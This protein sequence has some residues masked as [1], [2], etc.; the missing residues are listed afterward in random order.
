MS[1]A[2]AFAREGS[3]CARCFCG[4]ILFRLFRPYPLFCNGARGRWR[5]SPVMVRLAWG[6]VRI[7]EP[8][9]CEC[10]QALKLPSHFHSVILT[11]SQQQRC[12]VLRPLHP[13]RYCI[14]ILSNPH[15]SR[16]LIDQICMP[17]ALPFLH[18]LHCHPP[19]ISLQRASLAAH[20]SDTLIYL[21]ALR[22]S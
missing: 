22:L 8:D 20:A 1:S 17:L 18:Q 15:F 4:R 19:A 2:D 11:S 5:A 12:P 3:R 10:E 6:C 16:S 13:S 7:G 14:S 21:L 9:N